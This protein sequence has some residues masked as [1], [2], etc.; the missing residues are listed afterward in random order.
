M[1]QKFYSNK[2]KTL[3]QIIYSQSIFKIYP[4]AFKSQSQATYL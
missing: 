1:S 3:L 4:K 2:P